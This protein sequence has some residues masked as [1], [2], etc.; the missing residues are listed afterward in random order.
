[1]QIVTLLSDFGSG[2]PYPAQMKAAVAGLCHATLIDIS[3]DVRRHDVRM[4][5][6]LLASVAPHAPAGTVHLAVV[7]P[8]VG[9]ARRP[10][11]V[12]AGGQFFVGP[13]NGLLIP[14][15][16]RVGNP[17]VFEIT[18][19]EILRPDTSTTFHGRDI[20]APAAGRLAGGMPPDALGR[21]ALTWVNLEFGTGRRNGE[22][23]TGEI[24][25]VD[26]FGNLVTNIPTSLLKADLAPVTLTLRRRM[27]QGVTGRTYGDLAIGAVGIVP[28]SDG[29]LEIAVREGDAAAYTGTSA[30]HSIVIR[31]ER[32]RLRRG[33]QLQTGR[34][35]K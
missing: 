19:P 6:Y 22:V 15:A 4:G 35:G 9:T 1:M 32:G 27:F 23:I 13:D 16:R 5:A 17:R 10:L 24:I 14:A 11:I 33:K 25:Y 26:P 3:H 7:D 21:P 8:G 28:G 29:M 18:A 12:I 30:G 2:S 34:K 31:L 20:F